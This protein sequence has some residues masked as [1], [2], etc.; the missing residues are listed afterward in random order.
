MGSIAG[1]LTASGGFREGDGG[2]DS[3]ASYCD[4]IVQILARHADEPSA[5]PRNAAFLQLGDLFGDCTAR[6]ANKQVDPQIANIHWTVYAWL[7]DTFYRVMLVHVDG[8]PVLK[9]H[10]TPLIVHGDPVLAVD[11]LEVVPSLRD[12]VNG[13]PHR[14][15]STRLF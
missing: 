4:E 15:L 12:I 2:V 11:A 8:E 7:L 3:T 14:F 9:D 10:L 6:R 5:T 13:R 1:P